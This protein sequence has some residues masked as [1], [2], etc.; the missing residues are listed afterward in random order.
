MRTEF[1]GDRGIV[2]LVAT[3]LGTFVILSLVGGLWSQWIWGLL[4]I[5]AGLHAV[6]VISK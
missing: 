4:G 3:L 6:K 1:P 2:F 5:A